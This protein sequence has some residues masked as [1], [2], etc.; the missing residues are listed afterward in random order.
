MKIYFHLFLVLILIILNCVKL[1]AA[2]E[3]RC[4]NGD[5]PTS[6]LEKLYWQKH[7]EFN[8]II[9]DGHYN[10]SSRYNNLTV[11]IEMISNK[12]VCLSRMSKWP[13]D[14]LCP[15]IFVSEN[16]T[17]RYPN[18]VKYA[19]CGSSNCNKLCKRCEPVI[20]L[21]PILMRTDNC[22]DQGVAVWEFRLEKRPFQCYCVRVK[23]FLS[24]SNPM[25][26]V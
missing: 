15:Y 5:P 3:N 11:E 12:Q 7:K 23:S 24:L 25:M 21:K 13:H 16:R 4:P 1:E 18:L 22:S 19:V 6:Q 8:E 20:I 26:N 2:R 14:T 9:S 17:D 10:E